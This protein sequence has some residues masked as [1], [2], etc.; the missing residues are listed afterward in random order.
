MPSTK[1]YTLFSN[2]SD[3]NSKPPCAF[4]LSPAG[5][6]NGDNCKFSHEKVDATK[7]PARSPAKSPDPVKVECDSSSVVSSESEGASGSNQGQN[8]Q[9]QQQQRNDKSFSFVSMLENRPDF[10]KEREAA[11]NRIQQQLQQDN[12]AP[13]SQFC[14]PKGENPSNPKSNNDSAT[15][16]KKKRKAN[17]DVRNDLFSNPKKRT[18]PLPGSEVKQDSGYMFASPKNQTGPLP[19]SKNV[20]STQSMKQKENKPQSATRPTTSASVVSKS[21]KGGFRD[22]LP[23]LPVSTFSPSGAKS[24]AT[25]TPKNGG[26][27]PVDEP[28]QA[29]TVPAP[30]SSNQSKKMD[31]LPLPE[32]TESGREWYQAVMQTREHE[33]FETAYDFAK[34]KELIEQAGL[35]EGSW[36]KA[37]KFGPWCANN[38]Q[39]IAIDCEMCETQDPLSGAKNPKALCRV[40]VVNAEN[41]EEVLLDTLVKPSW[42]VTDYRSRINGVTKEHL[43]PVEFTLRHAQAFLMALCSDETVII[44]HAVDNDLAAL[45][46]EHHCV[47]DTSLLYH[48]KDSP[49]APVSLRDIVSS[50]FKVEMPAVH[51][52]VNDARKSLECARH[53]MLKDGN[54]EAI[55]RTSRNNAHQLFVHRIPKQCKASHLKNMFLNH[56]C[57]QPS[58]VDD[59]EFS[60]DTGKTH[61]SFRSPRHANLAFDTLEGTAEEEKSGRLQKKVYLR[62]GS[63]VRVRKMVRAK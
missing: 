32:S 47:V 46:M 57:I 36:I 10:E 40:S 22:L 20:N 7:G 6:R 49:T 24:P 12:D 11:R 52:S 59:I 18:G 9:P 15:K 39:A 44:G 38:P 63:Y 23:A 55:Q 25:S 27:T 54:V 61:V 37:K 58:E 26:Q 51:D 53:Y 14:V 30:S 33:R 62:N 34:Y 13:S 31:L 19:G 56:T 21:A 43:D 41:P 42:P 60:G 5:C 8:R 17:Q 28:E 3:P 2:S 16:N 35:T 29:K 45:Q 4:F 48:S 1:K 50:V